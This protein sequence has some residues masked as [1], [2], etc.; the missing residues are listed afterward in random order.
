MVLNNVTNNAYHTEAVQA[1]RV[2]QSFDTVKVV[3]TA[4]TDAAILPKL[5]SQLESG[6]LAG[7]G[8]GIHADHHA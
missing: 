1:D 6:Q 3:A 7:A 5:R 8:A 4:G 2:L